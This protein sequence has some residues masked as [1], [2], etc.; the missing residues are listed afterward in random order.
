M[1]KKKGVIGR[2]ERPGQWQD[3]LCRLLM[4]HYWRNPQ[5]M[6]ELG[7]LVTQHKKLLDSERKRLSLQS[8]AFR[9]ASALPL[10]TTQEHE[11]LLRPFLGELA[12][13]ASRWGLLGDWAVPILRQCA[14]QFS[15][16]PG[17][18]VGSPLLFHPG[19]DGS[20]PLPEE[21]FVHRIHV[22]VSCDLRED[23]ET[24]VKRVL[25][26][27]AR[28]QRDEALDSLSKV[29]IRKQDIKHALDDHVR[30]LY[31]RIALKKVPS[32]IALEESVGQDAVEKAIYQLA[33]SLSLRLPRNRGA[34]VRR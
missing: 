2:L 8:N 14:M 6:A 27:E 16:K 13:L 31:L 29:G 5:F 19:M 22:N 18:N 17:G 21:W 12:A 11:S 20:L 24:W 32:Q 28:R 30:W 34:S 9:P 25:E 1:A 23:W 26:P 10:P 33:R 3:I 4:A 7:S 15:L